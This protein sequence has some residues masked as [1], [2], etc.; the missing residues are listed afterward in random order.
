[1]ISRRARFALGWSRFGEFVEHVAHLVAPVAEL[2]RLGPHVAHGRPE[3]QGAV[4]DRPHWGP[5]APALQV[6]QH[7]R[8]AVGA[9][10]VAVLQGH[11]LLG[12]IGPY[13]DDH[14]RTEPVVL[15]P[16]VEMDAVDPHIH[17]V[18]VGQ[19]PL[20]EPPI[21][22]LP[23][24]REARDVGRTEAGRVVAQQHRQGLAEIA[25]R[26]APQVEDREHLRHLRRTA[27]V[28]GQNPTGEP[29]AQAGRVH[30]LVVHSWRRDLQRP[31]AARHLPRR[32]PAVPDDQPTPVFVAGLL[33]G[34]HILIFPGKS[35][36]SS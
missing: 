35:G 34:V 30:A 14:Q 28:R 7:R 9:L 21:V 31:S 24:R 27:H 25:R 17:V 32:R 22:L 5:H 8:P 4:A 1:M 16:D 23:H 2:S 26:Q 13:A 29:L 18:A 20:A 33:V 15:E 36:R 19:V 3:A 10:A 12:P 6:P 11:E